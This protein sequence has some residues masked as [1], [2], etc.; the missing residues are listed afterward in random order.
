MAVP[1]P[2]ASEGGL[3]VEERQDVIM[4]VLRGRDLVLREYRSSLIAGK[5][6]K[7]LGKSGVN[8]CFQSTDLACGILIS[9]SQ[10]V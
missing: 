8:V 7:Y 6:G 10:W 1:S 4:I 2:E 9:E 5:I 3:N